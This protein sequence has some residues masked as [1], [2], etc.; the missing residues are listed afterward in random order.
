MIKRR[1]LSPGYTPRRFPIAS[2]STSIS[3]DCIHLE[4]A[5]WQACMGGERNVRVS[6]VEFSENPASVLQRAIASSARR[7]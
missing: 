4:I 3:N 7:I 5:W 1:S 2:V 6:P